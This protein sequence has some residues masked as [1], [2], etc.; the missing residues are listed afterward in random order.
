[1]SGGGKDNG[2]QGLKVTANN[3]VKVYQVASSKAGA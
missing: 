3:G 1:M 2:L